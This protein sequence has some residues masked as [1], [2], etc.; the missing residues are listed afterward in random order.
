MK[1]R[2]HPE[3]IAEFAAAVDWYEERQVGLGDELEL[4]VFDALELVRERPLAWRA[5][6]GLPSVRVFPL[7]RFPFLLPYVVR[8]AEIVVLAVAHGRRRPGY[9]RDRAGEGER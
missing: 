2:F 9:W 5:W 7:D 3:A 6:P 8:G 4:D 1:L